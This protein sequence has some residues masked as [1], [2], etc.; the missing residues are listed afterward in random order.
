MSSKRIRLLLIEDNPADARL[1]RELLREAGDRQIETQHASALAEA[2]GALDAGT[3]DVVLADLSLPDSQGVETFKAVHA[4]AP[5]VPVVVL[6]GLADEQ[7]GLEALRHGAQDYLVKGSVNG[8]MLERA[9]RYAMERMRISCERDE[10]LRAHQISERRYRRFYDDTPAIFF[11]LDGDGSIRSVNR[12]GAEYLG[13]QP[14]QLIGEHFSACLAEP[15][16]PIEQ[17]LERVL[18]ANGAAH[19]ERWL[20]RHADGRSL[21]LRAMLRAAVAPDGGRRVLVACE[22]VTQAELDERHLSAVLDSMRD[23]IIACDAQGRLTLTN[24]AT[25]RLFPDVGGHW[26]VIAR[27]SDECELRDADDGTVVAPD[28]FPL[29]RALSGETITNAEYRVAAVDGDRVVLVS[30]QPMHTADGQQLGAVISLQD[31]TERR[32]IEAQ[33]QQAQKMEAVGQLTGGLAHDFNNLLAVIVGNLQLVGRALAKGDATIRRQL[34]AAQDAAMRGGKL[35]RQLLAFARRQVL[36]PQ[37][38]ELGRS[39]RDVEEI[40]VRTLGSLI[41]VRLNVP[42]HLWPVK[43]DPNLLESAL[44]NLIINARDAMPDGGKISIRASNTQLD[45]HYAAMNPDVQAGPFVMI[46]VSDTGCGIPKEMLERVLE[47]FFST[48]EVGRGTGLGLS[49][50]YGFVKQSGGHLKLYSEVG[51]GTVVRMYLPRATDNDLTQAAHVTAKYKTL[52]TGTET[53]LV[54]DDDPSLLS[55]SQSLLEG[56]GYRVIAAGDG[57]EAL[58]RIDAD[59]LIEAIFTDMVMPG[60]ISGFDLARLARAKRP[61]IKVLFTSGYTETTVLGDAGFDGDIPLLSKPY[62]ERELAIRIRQVLDGEVVS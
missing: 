11:T 32:G 10:A 55:V 7:T 21:T 25:E 12:F 17:D 61:A 53:V 19:L 4:S 3:V 37:I 27:W 35:T 31:V 14:H 60:D 30:G 45:K 15:A 36:E 41:D 47:P 56:L 46:A 16:H 2:L 42:E 59:P 24:R 57:S 5:T 34:A 9:L 8:V 51:K 29:R 33:L 40:V 28:R 52:P 23:A 48:K 38:V 49:M 50:V 26:P 20:V 18:G 39:I 13:Y 1:I 54:V 43:I 6:T 22:D 62:E 44:L 58:A